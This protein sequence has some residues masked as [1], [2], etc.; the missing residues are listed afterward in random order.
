MN[1]KI[2]LFLI[3]IPINTPLF[4]EDKTLL[5][6]DR[7]LPQTPTVAAITAYVDRP[8]SYFSGTTS[9]SVP[10]CEIDADGVNLPLSLSY[11]STGFRPSEEASW[12]GLGWSFSLNACISRSVKCAD[13]FMEYPI[14]S[15]GVYDTYGSGY[16]DLDKMPDSQLATSNGFIRQYH[17]ITDEGFLEGIQ[18]QVKDSE[19]DIYSLSMWDGGTKFTFS[20]DDSCNNVTVFVDKS[21]GWKAEVKIDEEESSAAHYF[22]MVAKDGTRYEFK[23]REITFGISRTSSAP[24]DSDYPFISSDMSQPDTKYASSWFLTKIMTTT[25]KTIYFDYEPEYYSCPIQSSTIKYNELNL[26]ESW[27]HEKSQYLSG[28]CRDLKLMPQYTWNRTC[29]KT[30]RLSKIRWS[31]GSIRLYTSSREDIYKEEPLPGVQKLD[32][33]VVY[34]VNGDVRYSYTM[35]Y[36]YFNDSINGN[37]A[38]LYKRLRLDKMTCNQDTSVNYSFSYN[39]NDKMPSKQSTSVDYWGYYNGQDYGKEFYCLSRYP[40]NGKM[41]VYDGAVKYSD[42]DCTML[43]ML[44]SVQHPTKGLEKFEYEQNEFKWLGNLFKPRKETIEKSLCT[45]S[46]YTVKDSVSIDFDEPHKLV[47]TGVMASMKGSELGTVNT[48]EPSLTIYKLDGSNGIQK[49]VTKIYPNALDDP[50]QRQLLWDK[51]EISVQEGTYR[52]VI[53]NTPEDLTIQWKICGERTV[54]PEEECWTKEV[55]MKGAGLRISS[56]EAG[57]KTR[58]F[59][60]SNGVLLIEPILGYRKSFWSIVHENNGYSGFYNDTGDL[61][62]KDPHSVEYCAD[63][64][65]QSSNLPNA[66]TSIASGN[67]VGYGLVTEI[68]DNV[69]TE[70]EYQVGREQRASLNPFFSTMP[71][72]TNGLLKN[73]RSME[74]GIIVSTLQNVWNYVPAPK[75]RGFN[76]DECYGATDYRNLFNISHNIL[77]NSTN[78]RK[79][80]F[81]KETHYEYDQSNLMCTSETTTSVSESTSLYYKYA[82]DFTDAVSKKMVEA[83][84]IG[85]PLVTLEARNGTVCSG[86]RTEYE[87]IGDKIVPC[88]KYILNTD[89][90][91]LDI[92]KCQFD[93]VISYRNYDQYCNPQEVIYKGDTTTYIWGYKGQY[94]IAGIK[95]LNYLDVNSKFGSTLGILLEKTD[96]KHSDLVQIRKAF[97]KASCNNRPIAI[98][99]CLYQPQVGVTEITEPSGITHTYRYD[100]AGRL[101]QSLFGETELHNTYRYHYADQSNPYNYIETIEYLNDTY[102]DSTIVRQNYD[103]W[104]R[105]S[106]LET[107]GVNTAGKPLYSWQTYDA[108]GRPDKAWT[109]VPSA[110]R[111]TES[112]FSNASLAVF[113]DEYGYAKT[114]YDALNR[115]TK[116]SMPG[117]A[118]HDRDKATRYEY[119]TNVDKEVRKY[120]VEG[121]SLVEDG[122]YEK[123]ALACT[124]VTDPDSVKICTYEDLFGHVVL[125]RRGENND[126]YFV[127]D[128]Y[129]RLRFVLSPMYQEQ[130]SLDKFGYEY[131]YDGRGNVKYKKLPG[132]TPIEY[133]Y[134]PADRV[135]KMQDGIL[136][137]AGKYRSYSYDGLGRLVSQSIYDATT[138]KKEYDETINYYDDY[139][140]HSN[141]NCPIENTTL[142]YFV[143]QVSSCADNMLTGCAQRTSTGETLLTAYGYDEKGRVVRTEKMGLDN[144]VTVTDRTYN[145]YDVVEKEVVTEY[146]ISSSSVYTKQ[147]ESTT[148]NKYDRLHTKLLGSSVIKLQDLTKNVTVTNTTQ[149][150]AYDEYGRVIGNN[151]DGKYSDMAYEYDKLH[152][153]LTKIYTPN[154]T[155]EQNLYRETDGKNPRWNGSISA[156]SWRTANDYVRRYDYEYDELNRRTRADYNYYRVGG[157]S[158]NT[159]T[160][161]KMMPWVGGDYEDYSVQYWYDRNSNITDIYR[162]GRVKLS[163]SS[164][165]NYDTLE[166]DHID[167]NGNQLKSYNV[168]TN[169]QPY[170]G[171]M[172]F[173]DGMDAEVEYSYDANG[174]LTWDGNKGLTFTYD[175]AGWPLSIEGSNNRTDYVYTPDGRKLREVHTQ[176]TSD[177]K[178]TV[179]TTD[180]WEYHGPLIVRDGKTYRY[181]FKGG[182]YTLTT[183][184]CHYFIQDY[185]GNN[186]IL[187]GSNDKIDQRTHYY[188]Y[189]STMGDISTNEIVDFKFGGKELDRTF[190]IDLYDFHARQYDPLIP[191]FTSIDPMAEKYYGISP[192]AYCCGDPINLIDTDG[193]DP[194]VCIYKDGVGHAFVTVGGGPN[195]VVYSYGRYGALGSGGSSLRALTPTGEGVLCRYTG[196]NAY[197]YL[198][199]VSKMELSV[200]KIKSVSD[201]EVSQYLDKLWNGGTQP[202]N[203]K[204]NSYNNP[205][206]RVIDEYNLFNNNCVTTSVGAINGGNDN[207]NISISEDAKISFSIPV[208]SLLPIPLIAPIP[209]LIPITIPTYTPDVLDQKLEEL[210]KTH[211]EDVIKIEDPRLFI[212]SY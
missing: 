188:P 110:T 91:S 103:E 60:Y 102:T 30:Y 12:V 203:P 161:L 204:K 184:G 191:S 166:D 126:T 98:T 198:R 8:V 178:T 14:G 156:M 90:A 117:K 138:K 79:G 21:Q 38:Y 120:A 4:S 59:K 96:F 169:G 63:Y 149:K 160:S 168:S 141:F 190:G 22:V 20:K 80:N 129:N 73:K 62:P 65:M 182:F 34:D 26:V 11:H 134:D 68:C 17:M 124:V 200:Y 50:H 35:T 100:A 205:D 148:Q 143:S 49:L 94:P 76:Y 162:K 36:G 207:S 181:L 27:G 180:A 170:Y 2:L 33:V 89:K 111:L 121:N 123:D 197:D 72:F 189:G 86:V 164:A 193:N 39:E 99:T 146:A 93:R 69:Q 116:V 154:Y 194:R 175:L 107:T 153:W 179:K 177:S 58:H 74:N 37:K 84:M 125:E 23:Q 115:K 128:D 186:R 55:P 16:Y 41:V 9:V 212:W 174:N 209:A 195:T 113:G 78:W 131:R 56:I 88:N 64:Y 145:F 172:D 40:K 106:I 51:I 31:T 53:E 165:R 61:I 108:M 44:T 18:F 46:P 109:A 29:F 1:R 47:L 43:G 5:K 159:V 97:N 48:N 199:K 210:S 144:H 66:L 87:I 54:Y 112:T 196:I 171:S 119:R 150:L 118:W 75:L 163:N 71:L 133:E 83:N 183:V 185:Q 211:P 151:R 101:S 187:M 10:L 25:G 81:T 130:K 7:F 104:G 3:A 42:Y 6:E 82:T 135:I 105:Q 201:E 13:D 77:I 158:N 152:G 139:K 19:P 132:C 92:A 67:L 140:F 15:N 173:N 202:T 142:A 28:D 192:Y 206:C 157:I 24:M 208:P 32:S 45:Y 114:S 127:Y 147:V 85:V 176:Y 70:Y 155:F 137:D 95:G 167:R 57:G 52:F 122:Y 136:R